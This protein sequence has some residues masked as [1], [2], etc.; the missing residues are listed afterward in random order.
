MKL[1]RLTSLS[2][3]HENLC[4]KVFWYSKWHKHPYHKHIHWFTFFVVVL[5]TGMTV[6]NSYIFKTCLIQADKDGGKMA[7]NADK[8]EKAEKQEKDKGEEKDKE[9]KKMKKKS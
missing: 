8:E 4:N 5:F 9:E 6:Y 1:L 7:M 2:R 3:H